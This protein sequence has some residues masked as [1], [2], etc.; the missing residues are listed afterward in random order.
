ME[1]RQACGVDPEAVLVV[2]VKPVV[3]ASAAAD[4]AA[5]AAE[6]QRSR[7][8]FA[9]VEESGG[10]AHSA[11]SEHLEDDPVSAAVMSGPGIG[12]AAAA[13]PVDEAHSSVGGPVGGA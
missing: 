3:G 10:A 6:Q 12:S 2:E 13:E 4:A 7:A 8:D 5:A 1:V 9:V 11:A